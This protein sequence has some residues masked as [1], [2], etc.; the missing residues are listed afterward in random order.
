MPT[1]RPSA[2]A[3]TSAAGALA[4]ALAVVASTVVVPFGLPGPGASAGA[5]PVASPVAAALATGT[6]ASPASSAS[7]VGSVAP[8]A[9]PAIPERLDAALRAWRRAARV[10]GVVAAV[11]LPD[12]TTWT[13]AAGG[14][15]AGTGSPRATTR[16]PWVIASITKTFV[17]ALA[18]RLAEEGVLS[19]D[20]PIARWVPEQ[21]RA[22]RI[23]LRMLL[24]HTSGL[25]DYFWHPRYEA[26]VFGRPT[27]RWTTDEILALAAAR[28]PLFR[29]GRGWSYSNTNYVLAGRI[30]E[31]AAGAPL[32]EQLRARFF[33]PLGLASAVLQGDEPVPDGAAKG[34]LRED[35]AWVD[36]SDGTTLRPM[37]SAATVA[38]A[39]GAILLSA[40]DLLRWE[41]ALYGGTVLSPGSLAQMLAFGPEGYGLGARAQW[42]AGRPGYGHGGSLRGFV[43]AM[44]R[45]PS[46][47]L[48]VVALA[49]RGGA[50]INGLADALAQAV[51]GPPPT[52]VPPPMPLAGASPSASLPPAPSVSPAG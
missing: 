28:R 9:T 4:L 8:L 41:E 25:A 39:A 12:G 15:E 3:R 37:T 35:R 38:W 32:A 13:G 14:R 19:L 21:K 23:T 30:L 17:A 44:Y 47:G 49:N 27:Y 20:E 50:D 31:I 7:P 46:A 1:D 2:T 43:A 51:V 18:L 11:R 24:A 22:G 42:L 6:P 26:L 52:P 48:A 10:P 34:Y 33:T 5:S 45:V 29:P 40:E 16:T 36:L